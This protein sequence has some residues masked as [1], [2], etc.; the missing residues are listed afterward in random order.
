MN[1]RPMLQ[2]TKKTA[3]QVLSSELGSYHNVDITGIQL[4]LAERQ[5]EL[6]HTSRAAIPVILSDPDNRPGSNRSTSTILDTNI[7]KLSYYLFRIMFPDQ[8][9]AKKTA[10][11]LLVGKTPLAEQC[12]KPEF[13]RLAPPLHSS[14]DE[15]SSSYEPTLIECHCV[16]KPPCSEITTTVVAGLVEPVSASGPQGGL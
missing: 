13:L 7:L 16:D 15:V 11:A 9:V 14:E 1:C 3:G 2:V 12:V 6:P 5:S 8:N 4:A 10:E